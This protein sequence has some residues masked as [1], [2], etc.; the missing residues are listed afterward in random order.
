MQAI[1]VV[2]GDESCRTAPAATIRAQSDG[3]DPGH[4]QRCRGRSRSTVRETDGL[5]SRGVDCSLTVDERKRTHHR[6]VSSYYKVT[7]TLLGK[8]KIGTTGRGIGPL[9]DK[10]TVSASACSAP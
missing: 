2:V 8:H 4:R 10:T 6:A 1:L 5:E 7:G 3:G 9:T